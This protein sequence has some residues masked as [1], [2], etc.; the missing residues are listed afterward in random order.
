MTQTKTLKQ[1]MAD[2]ETLVALRGFITT[3]KS[4]LAD[5]WSTGAYDYIWIDS[6]HTVFDEQM[7]ADY[8]AAA[9]EL[10]IDVQLRIPHTYHSYL[11][12]RFF[13]LGCTAALVP[14]VMK[15]ET[16]SD[17][18]DFA[19]YGPIGRRS[20]GGAARRNMKAGMNR[21]E[22]A[23]WWNDYGLL[24]IQ[25]ESVEMVSNIRKLAKPGVCFVTFGPNDLLF[26]IEDHPDYPL[27][28]VEDCMRN[29]VAQLKG[30]NIR[31]AM[32][33]PTKPEERGPYLEMGVTLFQQDA[34]A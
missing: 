17:A 23:K 14:E 34:P 30:T 20:W 8:C 10:G 16:V 5:I 4:E 7:F 2:G 18:L 13:D 6:Q 31:V 19:Y 28:T 11:V 25:C 3:T 9:E 21:H 24:G 22:Y 29:V 15:E 32:G 27:Q 26:N 12:G 1:R 33:T